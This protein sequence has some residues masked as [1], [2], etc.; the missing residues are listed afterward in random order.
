[1]STNWT[2]VIHGGAG[3]IN[4]GVLTPEQARKFD[5]RVAEALTEPAP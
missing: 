1:M 4:R 5:A 2:L 3:I